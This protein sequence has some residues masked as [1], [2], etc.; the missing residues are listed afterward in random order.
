MSNLL[1]YMTNGHFDVENHLFEVESQK[2]TKNKKV[3]RSDKVEE[4]NKSRYAVMSSRLFH[5][6]L[7]VIHYSVFFQTC[8]AHGIGFDIKVTI[9]TGNLLSK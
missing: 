8:R 2:D 6:N 1:F 7:A 9:I 4:N 5:T 3:K